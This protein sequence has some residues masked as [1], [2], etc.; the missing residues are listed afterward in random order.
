MTATKRVNLRAGFLLLI[1]VSVVAAGQLVM[2]QHARAAGT[3]YYIDCVGGNDANN[4]MSTS[5][6][7][8]T[9]TNTNSRTFQPGD[10][11]LLKRGTLCYG[12]GTLK[13]LGSGTTANPITI[14]AYGTG[15]L[16]HIDCGTGSPYFSCVLV[17]DQEAW[18]IRDLEV[19]GTPVDKFNGPAGI[20]IENTIAGA[21]SYFRIYNVI[22]HDLYYGI[23]IS[24]YKSGNSGELYGSIT[25]NNTA[26]IND[27]VIDGVEA[28]NN[29]GKGIHLT[30]NWSR[31][32]KAGSYAFPHNTN[33]TVRNSNLHNN[34]GDGIVMA[35]SDNVLVEYVT[36]NYNGGTGD[37]RY[38][39][40]PWMSA[41]STV[42][43]SE[44]AFNETSTN[45]GGG[46]LDC[47]YGTINCVMQYNYAHDN[48]GPG[49]LLIGYG[50]ANLLNANVHYNLFVDNM[51]HATAPDDGE[52][53]VFGSVDN[54]VFHNNTIYARNRNNN[55]SKFPAVFL[56]TWGKFG[57]PTNLQIKNN[58]FYLDNNT[59][60]V[61]QEVGGSYAFDYNLLYAT[62][63]SLRIRWGNTEYTTLAAFQAATGQ[64]A[65]SIYANPLLV[66][67]GGRNTSDYQI[68]SNSLAVNAGTNLGALMG[69]RDFFGNPIPQG[70]AF[71]IGAH[72][73]GGGPLPTNTPGGP[74]PTSTFT[75]IPP[76]PTFTPTPSA[77]TVM[78]VLDIWTTDEAGAPKT[79]FA[80]GETLYWHVKIV[81]QNG[82]PVSGATV[83]T[84]TTK[85]NGSGYD[86]S[87]TTGADGV[88]HFS[89]KTSGGDSLGI[90]TIAVTNVTK[91][92]ATYNPGANVKSSTT[93]TLQ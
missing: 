52:L 26:Y 69:P 83:I 9:F 70:G 31:N 24:G 65:H 5:S 92:G 47:D 55:P 64:D 11:I 72:E 41:N 17:K 4:G 2:T 91:T 45:K 22:A 90:W 12:I 43:F 30:G 54:S 60:Y 86:Q 49:I 77:S 3:I 66:N 73:T 57:S 51:W 16:P 76:T 35:C 29:T 25:G 38:G 40:W 23:S 58:I 21:K 14:G 74:T 71:D 33:I 53:V 75:P 50:G 34:G 82:N 84:H 88:A 20:Y 67:P 7:W 78:H 18:V 39:I 28:Y 36:A 19:S 93:F 42:Q 27:V 6:P 81:D 1:A 56:S 61:Y 32:D 37:D 48:Q 46:G 15:A 85:P 87:A 13:P 10:Q 8:K 80:R 79:T 89:K 68:A 62:S 63:G 44:A 59:R